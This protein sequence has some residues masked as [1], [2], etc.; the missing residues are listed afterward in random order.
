MKNRRIKNAILEKNPF[1]SN[2][3]KILNNERLTQTINSNSKNKRINNYNSL[4]NKK[5]SDK[6]I[7]FSLKIIK[8]DFPQ[9]FIP[10][11]ILSNYRNKK[12]ETNI[13]KQNNINKDLLYNKGK[14]TKNIILLGET[15]KLCEKLY[16]SKNCY[17]EIYSNDE[18][19][20][21]ILLM[22]RIMHRKVKKKF[23]ENNNNNYYLNTIANKSINLL[24]INYNSKKINE[25]KKP[26]D[27]INLSENKNSY[28]KNLK[29]IIKEQ[30]KED[31]TYLQITRELIPCHKIQGKKNLIMEIMQKTFQFIT[32][33]NYI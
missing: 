31:I 24:K 27:T 14:E 11:I 16:N 18:K 15:E 6:P 20:L 21:I 28:I 5:K 7:S 2:Q 33:L 12:E 4:S 29:N 13:M 8:L 19:N 22:K 9:L 23:K 26:S 10:N 32:I 30:S 1:L 17:N 25:I 3:P